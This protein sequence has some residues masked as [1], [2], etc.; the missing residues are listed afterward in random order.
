MSNMK[1]VF[2]SRIA[3]YLNNDCNFFDFVF[4]SATKFGNSGYPS[5]I[6]LLRPDQHALSDAIQTFERDQYKLIVIY[7]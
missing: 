5:S 6:N 2:K 7:L 1:K 3:K 4:E